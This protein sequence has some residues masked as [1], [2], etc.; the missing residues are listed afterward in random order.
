MRITQ[1]LNGNVAM[2]AS[3]TMWSGFMVVSCWSKIKVDVKLNVL[4]DHQGIH[5]TIFMP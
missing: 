5:I 3:N 4:L 2:A 1:P